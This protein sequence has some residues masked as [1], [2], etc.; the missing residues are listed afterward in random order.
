MPRARNP[1]SRPRTDSR[2]RGRAVG[3]HHLLLRVRATCLVGQ[4]QGETLVIRAG[5]VRARR[6][7]P[8]E[9]ESQVRLSTRRS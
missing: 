4:S 5:L 2:V 1:G 3:P 6:G 9:P 7:T 8:L